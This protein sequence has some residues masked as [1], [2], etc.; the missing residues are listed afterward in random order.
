MCLMYIEQGGSF[1]NQVMGAQK[2][3]AW[4]VPNLLTWS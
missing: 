3:N 2:I 4:I 1:S